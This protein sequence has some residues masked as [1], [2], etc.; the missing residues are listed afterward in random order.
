MNAYRG[1]G[2]HGQVV[3][4]L[5]ARI[6]SGEI[7]PG[8]AIDLAGLRRD[9]GVSLTVL[10]EAM[11]VLA[12]KGLLEARPKR[13][14]HVRPRVHWNLL[15]SDVIIW[16]S[17]AGETAAVLS[18]L[19]DLRAIV[20]PAAASLAASR[21]TGDDLAELDAALA[22]MRE[23]VGADAEATADL[24]WHRA[25]LRATHNEMLARMDIFIEP[26][27]RLRDALVHQA[28]A[29]DPVPSHA[30]V[31]AAVRDGDPESAAAALTA[32]LHKATE[33]ADGAIRGHSAATRSPEE[34][35]PSRS[36]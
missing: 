27:L 20:E 17:E 35:P 31:V 23:A 11:K 24:R 8:A 32:L 22:A 1:R 19:A 34:S 9:L 25:L 26:A 6:V 4:S 3:A 33:D 10:R 5:G 28:A 12:A 29:D 15:D 16:R 21:R 7:G 2:V 30:A 36:D 13:G 14:T 18:D